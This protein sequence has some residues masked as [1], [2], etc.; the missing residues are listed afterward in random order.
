MAI[1]RA[2][3]RRRVRTITGWAAGG[4]V[5][6]TAAFAFGASRGGHVA[7]ANTRSGSG[8]PNPAAQDAL[9]QAPQ[10][11]YP[12]APQGA[13]PQDPQA[14]QGFTPPSASTVP[15]AAMSGGS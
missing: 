12:Q 2:G 15:P 6:L 10:S 7:K 11:A 8:S 3:A 13:S 4:A 5:A 14:A 1:D 9:P